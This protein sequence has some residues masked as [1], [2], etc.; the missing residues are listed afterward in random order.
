MRLLRNS[1]RCL[2]ISRVSCYVT[3]QYRINA[4]N[5]LSCQYTSDDGLHITVHCCGITY[6]VNCSGSFNLG[7]VLGAHCHSPDLR[8]RALRRKGKTMNE[9]KTKVCGG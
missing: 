5:D 9:E 3:C 7:A 8:L 4:L 1:G 6:A 2:R